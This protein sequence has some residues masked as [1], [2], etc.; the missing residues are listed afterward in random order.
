MM[1]VAAVCEYEQMRTRVAA[2]RAAVGVS[3]SAMYVH[4]R[5]LARGVAK[6]ECSDDGR[7]PSSSYDV[8]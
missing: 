7:G 8:Q 2:A 1:N 6:H 4:V 3:V 5:V